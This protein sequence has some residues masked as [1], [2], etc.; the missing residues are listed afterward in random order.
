MVFWIKWKMFPFIPF[1]FLMPFS[2]CLNYVVS[3]ISF[4]SMNFYNFFVHEKAFHYHTC[5]LLI[6]FI[7]ILIIILRSFWLWTKTYVNNNFVNVVRCAHFLKL[8]MKF[9]KR[10][11]K[12][13]ISYSFC[14]S[15]LKFVK[16]K[17]CSFISTGALIL[18][19]VLHKNNVHSFLTIFLHY[20]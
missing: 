3:L 7:I 17:R 5:Y 20:F 18:W 15:F 4:C 11:K 1:I 10:N 14:E 8:W 13:I 6:L 12:K 9:L 19:L 16:L 2:G